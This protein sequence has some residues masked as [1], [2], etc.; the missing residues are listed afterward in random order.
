MA[1]TQETQKK[2]ARK[3]MAGK[4]PK[5]GHLPIDEILCRLDP[6]YGPP[7][8]PRPYDAISE[9]IF[10]VLSQH[11]SD[12][13]SYRAN[14][15]MRERFTTWEALMKADIDELADAIQIGGLAKVK[16]PRIQAILRAILERNGG[17]WD[18]SFLSEMPLNEAKRWLLEL[19]GVGP[20]TAGCVLLFALGRPAM[21][22]DT[23]VYRVAQRLGLI[24]P[25]V[26]ADEAHDL[27]EDMTPDDDVL[28]AHVYIITHG[29]RVCKA[30][31]PLCPECTLEDG[32]PSS[33]LK[34]K[35]RRP[36]KA[37]AKK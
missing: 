21:V 31:N 4:R 28:A 9:L 10:T 30:Q 13:N 12:V 16:A 18:L 26:T 19:P 22:V 33:T 6:L 27:L 1:T 24:G 36:K 2:P 32:C 35:K 14:E 29:R 8:A 23:H 17:S 5:K 3:S 15:M 20:K 7:E 34:S 37:K 25:K 11:T